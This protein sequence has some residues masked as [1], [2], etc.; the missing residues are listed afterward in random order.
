MVR[1]GAELEHRPPKEVELYGHLDGHGG[2][3]EGR[4]L[5]SGKDPQRVAPE[6]GFVL[7]M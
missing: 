4:Y 7:G 5:V 2:V 1:A 6:G 3:A